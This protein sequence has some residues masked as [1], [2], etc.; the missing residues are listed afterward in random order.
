[1]TNINATRYEVLEN[2][3]IR[4]NKLGDDLIGTNK[5]MFRVGFDGSVYAVTETGSTW[6]DDDRTLFEVP[7]ISEWGQDFDS[8]EEFYEY[9]EE[10]PSEFVEI[11]SEDEMFEGLTFEE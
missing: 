6:Y 10:N 5:L 3:Q 9:V 8:A 1:M 4:I 7:Q 11:P 2:L